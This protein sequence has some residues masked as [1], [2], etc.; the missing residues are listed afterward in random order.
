MFHKRRRKDRRRKR[1]KGR[2]R[3][4]S[5]RR[6][7]SERVVGDDALLKIESAVWKRTRLRLGLFLL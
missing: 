6:R 1:K 2:K 3:E 5:R 4:R 7:I